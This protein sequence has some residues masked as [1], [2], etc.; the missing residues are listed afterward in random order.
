MACFTIPCCSDRKKLASVSHWEQELSTLQKR[1][2]AKCPLWPQLASRPGLPS[3]S[4][5]CTSSPACC[6]TCSQ[7]IPALRSSLSWSSPA[8]PLSLRSPQ[9]FAPDESIQLPC[10]GSTSPVTATYVG[11]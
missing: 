3:D 9:S 5:L 4:L 10:C 2:R 1:L 11:C 6:T 7:Q 8:L